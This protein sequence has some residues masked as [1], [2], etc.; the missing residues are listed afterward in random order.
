MELK[1]LQYFFFPHVSLSDTECRHFG[2]LL[3][4]LSLLQ[5]LREPSVP[6]W[7]RAKFAGWQAVEDPQVSE[8]IGNCYRGYQEY[9]QVHQEDAIQASLS[10]HAILR[11]ACESRIL[12]QRQL[13]GKHTEDPQAR[14]SQLVEAATFLEMSLDL[15][16]RE[17]EL[18]TS[19]AHLQSLEGEFR[20]I[21]GIGAAED[22]EDILG[23]VEIPLM[24]D[25]A[26]LSFM[27]RRRIASWFQLLCNRPPNGFPVFVTSGDEAVDELL[28]PLRAACDRSGNP[29]GVVR[30]TVA[31][32]P[33]LDHLEPDSFQNLLRELEAS[34]GLSEFHQG[35]EECIR[36]PVDMAAKE[37]LSVF[38]EALQKRI[39]GLLKVAG[40]PKRGNLNLVA[41]CLEGHSL[42]DLLKRLDK[43]LFSV[44][45]ETF[46][47]LEFPIVFLHTSSHGAS[48]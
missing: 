33:S 41:T 15:D 3:P 14:L 42:G 39:E 27:L 26:S 4:Q 23:A 45:E 43:N 28:E 31:S 36:N 47:L 13:R 12:I 18:Q 7:A 46:S 20:D 19:F 8:F 32:I 25:R 16:E 40:I 9:A 44:W 22:Q 17:R 30:T 1:I 24:S 11:E 2:L 38:S 10:H 29:L 48:S 37:R 34:N 35:M 5:V 6:E 21:L